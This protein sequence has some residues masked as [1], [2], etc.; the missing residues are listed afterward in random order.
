MQKN[1]A[2]QPY[3][4]VRLLQSRIILHEVMTVSRPCGGLCEATLPVPVGK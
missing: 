2:G 3:G 4:Q 1:N